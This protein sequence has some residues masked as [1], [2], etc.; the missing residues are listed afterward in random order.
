MPF[1]RGDKF[2]NTRNGMTGVVVKTVFDGSIY[3]EFDKTHETKHLGAAT[4]KRWYR[5]LEVKSEDIKPAPVRTTP[6]LPKGE[7]GCGQEMFSLFRKNFDANVPEC[8]QSSYTYHP[9]SNTHIFRING[10]NV[11][12]VTYSN[13]RLSVLA[14]KKHMTPEQRKA[15]YFIY[16]K[17]RHWALS[18]RY[19]FTDIGQRALMKAIIISGIYGRSHKM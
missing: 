13:Y 17:E 4:V 9:K 8:D 14:N 5:P 1:I 10:R 3:A 18:V 2:V 12:E 7:K 11:F 19:I 15:A 6:P 16:P